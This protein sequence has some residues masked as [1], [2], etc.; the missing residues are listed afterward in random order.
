MLS[1]AREIAL[2]RMT[3]KAEEP[4]ADAVINVRFMITDVVGGAAELFTYKTAVTLK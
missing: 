1:K 2:Q 3:K 4:G